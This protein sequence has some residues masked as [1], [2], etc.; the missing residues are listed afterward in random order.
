[1]LKKVVEVQGKFEHIGE[2]RT[3]MREVN[4]VVENGKTSALS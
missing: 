4:K 1:M 3:K 2:R